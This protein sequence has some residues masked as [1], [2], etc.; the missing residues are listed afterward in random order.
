MR[1]KLS[2][3]LRL[4]QQKNRDKRQKSR[5]LKE[6][7]REKSVEVAMVCKEEFIKNEKLRFFKEAMRSLKIE[8]KNKEKWERKKKMNKGEIMRNENNRER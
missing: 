2:L 5:W 7:R 6:E 4:R 8:K 3:V 1:R